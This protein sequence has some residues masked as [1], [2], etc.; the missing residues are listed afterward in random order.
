MITIEIIDPIL[1]KGRAKKHELTKPNPADKHDLENYY[2]ELA[3]I[4][5]VDGVAVKD[6]TVSISSNRD[7]SQNKTLVGTGDVHPIFENEVRLIVPI[8]SYHY[9]FN[10]P[11][12]HKILFVCEGVVSQINVDVQP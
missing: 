1:G 6:K 11:G 12:T 10:H 9:E 8:Y 5:R 7:A 4:V 3:C 2:I